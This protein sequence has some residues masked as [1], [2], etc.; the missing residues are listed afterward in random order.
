VPPPVDAAID[1]DAPIDRVWELVTDLG[2]YA[3]WNPFI[4]R[5]DLGAQGVAPGA[6]IRLHVRWPGGGKVVSRERISRVEP[7]VG[8]ASE[9]RSALFAYVYEGLPA[10]LGLVRATRTQRL[11]QAPGG[12]TR[13]TSRLEIAG[14][15]ARF[16]PL[17]PIR[18]GCDRQARALKARAESP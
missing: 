17:G 6:P 15:A 12:P 7:P 10:R 9:A 8:P 11:A 14:P 3:S 16:I 13:Y 5:V 4:V 2:A 18:E 1:I